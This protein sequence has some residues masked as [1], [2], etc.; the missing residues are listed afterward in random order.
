[1]DHKSVETNEP[2]E[3]RSP[4]GARKRRP[5]NK[6]DLDATP[7][8]VAHEPAPSSPQIFDERNRSVAWR[9]RST[10][11]LYTAHLQRLVTREGVTIGHWYYLRVLAEEDGLAQ[12]ELSKRVGIAATTAV[13]ALDDME[14]HGL[15]LRQRDTRDR[16]RVCI[17]LTPKGRRLLNEML[18]SV[19]A[20]LERSVEGIPG[21]DMET[22]FRVLTLITENLKENPSDEG[23]DID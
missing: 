9:I 18:P 5:A 1:M 14:K 2:V 3:L 10:F 17:F 8:Q 16:R 11:R 6:P 13:P 15:V 19:S 4:R 21:K 23:V 22:F 12:R 20:L 7:D